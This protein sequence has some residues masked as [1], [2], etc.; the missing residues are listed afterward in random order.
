MG[1]RLN[2]L[3][4]PVFMAELKLMLLL[5]KFVV[6]HRLRCCVKTS[7]WLSVME[8]SCTHCRDLEYARWLRGG[9]NHKAWQ[10]MVLRGKCLTFIEY[11]SLHL[12]DSM[13]YWF[14]TI[15]GLAPALC[16]TITCI[17]LCNMEV[18]GTLWIWPIIAQ[19][20]KYFLALNFHLSK[21]S[22]SEKKHATKYL[23]PF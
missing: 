21:S 18:Q 4:E 20:Y 8:F 15:R 14:I 1:Y 2:R 9:C 16:S 3:D 7:S 13:H 12:H 19:T 6:L 10:A 17:L 23:G 5:I 22:I 11:F